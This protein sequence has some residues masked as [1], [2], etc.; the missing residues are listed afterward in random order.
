MT[1]TT[2]LPFLEPFPG[3]RDFIFLPSA[4]LERR[5]WIYGAEEDPQF[6]LD[7]HIS[8]LIS[9]GWRVIESSPEVVAEKEGA[10]LSVSTF[11]RKDQIRIIYDLQSQKPS[12][13]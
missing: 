6:I 9:R 1:E 5:T 13:A 11:R 12:L 8:S 4:D 10:S 7:F 3:I 2:L